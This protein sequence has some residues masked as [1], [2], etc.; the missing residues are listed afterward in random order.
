M[1]TSLFSLRRSGLDIA[2]LALVL[3]GTVHA[4]NAPI[5]IS[6]IGAKATADY[7]GDALG[8]TA[9]PDGARLHC[10]FQKLVGHATSQGFWLESTGSSG[11]GSF[12]LTAA[13]L[14][15]EGSRA[16]EGALTGVGTGE[17]SAPAHIGGYTA[18]EATGKVD[19]ADKLVRFLRPWVTEEYSVSVDGVR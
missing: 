3:T 15:R 18:L 10:G 9:E 1:K 13:A 12:R 17:V 14:G 11:G 6:E 2:T 4:A 8:I 16:R 5:P 19:V 7:Q